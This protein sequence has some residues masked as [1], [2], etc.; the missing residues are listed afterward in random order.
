MPREVERKRER[1]RDGNRNFFRKTV[2]RRSTR[3]HNVESLQLAKVCGRILLAK[4]TRSHH[5]KALNGREII[6]HRSEKHVP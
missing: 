1:E 4:V 3:S 5:K 6:L 2:I